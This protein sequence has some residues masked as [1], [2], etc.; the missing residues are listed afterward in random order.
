VIAVVGL[1]VNLTADA[2]YPTAF[3]NGDGQ[4]L[5]SASLIG[6]IGTPIELTDKNTVPSPA[7]LLAPTTSPYHVFLADLATWRSDP[8]H[9]A[10]CAV[11]AMFRKPPWAR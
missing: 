8:C 4:P 11:L 7:T 10:G 9:G 6:L 1:G 3:T 5:S 2:V